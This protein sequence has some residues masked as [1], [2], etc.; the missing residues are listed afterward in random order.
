MIIWNNEWINPME[1]PWSIFEKVCFANHITRTEVLRTFG[2]LDVKKIK[3]ASIGDSR[4]ELVRLSGFD[5]NLVEQNLEYDLFGH[6]R[7]TI[8]TILKPVLYYNEHVNTWFPMSLR[9]CEQC[10]R[11]GYHSWLHQFALVECCPTHKTKLTNLCPTCSKNIPFLISDKML[12]DPFTCRCGHKLADFALNQWSEWNHRLQIADDT[13]NNWIDRGERRWGDNNRLLFNPSAVSIHLVHMP[14][15]ITSRFG[16]KSTDSLSTD[17]FV[18]EIYEEN[19]STFKAIDNYIRNKMLHKHRNCIRIFHE[20]KKQ[21]GEEFF[22]ICPYAYAYIYWKHTL[23]QT[24]R[25]YIESKREMLIEPR[26]YHNLEFITK[27]LEPH[28]IKLKDT[29]FKHTNL[30]E[31]YNRRFVHWIINRYTIEFCLNYFYRWMGIAK[32]GAENMRVPSWTE[33][34][35]MVDL[36]LPKIVYKHQ[37]DVN[38]NQEV[39]VSIS[40]DLSITNYEN[41]MR[42]VTNTKQLRK[43]YH[44]MRSFTPMNMA[45]KVFDNSTTENKQLSHYVDRYVSRLTI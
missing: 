18:N 1:T 37:F 36:S 39:E 4:R 41:N 2:T 5:S 22:P 16:Y 42:C 32:V 12:G 33:V 23:L 8:T 7:S 28:L 34:R 14:P 17:E 24:N 26:E 21:E 25:F 29:I 3:G 30:T 11:T 19:K 44:L 15:L 40:N 35:N 9:W 20:L 38:L 31:K 27:L 43:E 6:N 10:M 45:M 13:V